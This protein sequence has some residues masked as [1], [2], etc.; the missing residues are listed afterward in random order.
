MLGCVA[1]VIA[2]VSPSHPSP[3]VIHKTSIS[4]M[5]IDLR[6]MRRADAMTKMTPFL[7]GTVSAEKVTR[8]SCASSTI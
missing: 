4:A 2:I 3:A 6:S 1:P 8:P 7:C 5:G